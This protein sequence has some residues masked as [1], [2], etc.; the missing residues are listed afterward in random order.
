MGKRAR[1]LLAAALLLGG[2]GWAQAQYVVKA[3]VFSDKGSYRQEDLETLAGVHAGQALTTEQLGAAAGRLS[4]S[5]FF[6]QVSATVD[7]ILKSVSVVFKVKPVSQAEWLHAS[8]ENFVWF[9]PDELNAAIHAQIPLFGGALPVAGPVVDAAEAALRQALAARGIS[10]DVTHVNLEPRFGHP[11]R[12][13]Q[14]VVTKHAVVLRSA[15][16]TGVSAGLQAAMQ[17]QARTLAG[18]RYSEGTAGDTTADALLAPYLDAGYVDAKLTGMERTVAEVAGRTEVSVK[19][20]VNEGAVYRLASIAYSGSEVYSSADFAR[21]NKLHA[22]DPISRKLLRETLMPI[23]E[24]YR[25]RGYMDAVAD[26]TGTRDEA[27]HHIAYVVTVT[28]GEVYHVG[29]VYPLGLSAAAQADFDRGWKLKPGDVYSP[30]YVATFLKQ[31]TAL[32]ALNGYS[33]S[34][35]ASADP[36]THLVDVTI[37]FFAPR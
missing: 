8:F 12:Y 6:D 16:L 37:Q 29:H 33:A 10:G 21:G 5:G 20:A 2:C 17:K 26:V 36:E 19:A 3:V 11:Q 28:P 25:N 31:N 4:D 13:M 18:K 32:Q 1:V 9:T 14:F 22:D 24:A 35:K 27:T 23:D 30:G 15:E 34:F 7:G